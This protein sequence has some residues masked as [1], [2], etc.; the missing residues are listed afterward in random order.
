VLALPHYRH[1]GY[2][3]HANPTGAA[4]ADLDTD[5]R[6]GSAAHTDVDTDACAGAVK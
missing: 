1:V 6:A 4:H 5:T 2:S 3:G